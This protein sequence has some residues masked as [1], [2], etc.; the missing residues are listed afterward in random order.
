[1]AALWHTGNGD[2]VCVVAGRIS[3]EFDAALVDAANPARIILYGSYAR[4]EASAD[5][6]IEMMAVET[7]VHDRLKE[8]V[9]LNCVVDSLG[10]SVDLLVISKE[11]FDY[12]RDTP[13]DVYFEA[14]AGAERSMKRRE[15]G[16]PAPSQSRAG[17]SSA[18]RGT[19]LS[20]RG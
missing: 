15:A 12:R 20:E 3:L 11:K 8:T 6:D 4:G 16:A 13:G 17:R 9:R 10:V 14:V 5:S 19:R 7:D 18:G 1:M 2:T